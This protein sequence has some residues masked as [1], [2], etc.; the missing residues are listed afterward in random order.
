[1]EYRDKSLRCSGCGRPFLWTAPE[2]FFYAGRNLREP[3]R[4]AGCR[5]RQ[6]S[7]RTRPAPAARTDVTC[8]RCG[9]QASVPFV[10]REDRPVLCD[11]CFAAARAAGPSATR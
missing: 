9:R 2:Q 3:K 11:T 4:C 8:A 1:L 5:T 7:S 6:K 10:P